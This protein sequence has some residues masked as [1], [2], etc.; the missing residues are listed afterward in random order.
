LGYQRTRK[1]FT[2][3]GRPDFKQGILFVELISP[4]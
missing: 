2:R 1:D 4:F 3:A